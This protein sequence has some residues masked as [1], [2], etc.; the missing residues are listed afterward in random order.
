MISYGKAWERKVKE[1]FLKLPD[2][3]CL[4][5][6]DQVTG[7]K[8][9]SQNPCDFIGFAERQL[10]MLECKSTHGTTINFSAMKQY[11]RLLAYKNK[12]FVHPGI[13]VW[14]NDYSKVI[15]API[16]TL[17][18]LKLDGFKSINVTLLNSDLKDYNLI[19]IPFIQKRIFPD[20]D[21]TVLT[22]IGK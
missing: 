4:R 19:I 6:P 8:T 17:E 14:F 5:L 10:F 16:K 20:C 21:Y 1:D 15:F 13:L 11:N 12:P 18:K 7:Y 2:S 3:V 22:K 9:T